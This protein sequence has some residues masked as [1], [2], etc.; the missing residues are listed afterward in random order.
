MLTFDNDD[1]DAGMSLDPSRKAPGRTPAATPSPFNRPVRP[2][3]VPSAPDT[4]AEK[5]EPRKSLPPKSPFGTP[6]KPAEKT[7][8]APL[9]KRLPTAPAKKEFLPAK[10]IQ[11]NF[12][13][14]E[15]DYEEPVVEADT[16]EANYLEDLLAKHTQP[17]PRQPEYSQQQTQA[18]QPAYTPAPSH[19]S[20]AV[21]TPY[22][23]PPVAL[24]SPE[25]EPVTRKGK[26]AKKSSKKEP[27][28]KKT[29][30][31]KPE[32]VWD[33]D[34][35][36]ILY[37]RLGV[38]LVAG[39]LLIAGMKSIVAPNNGPSPAQVKA[40]AQEAVNYTG[41]PTLSGEQFSID[42]ART[43]FNYDNN[44]DR[45][46]EAL[47]NFGSEELIKKV[48]IQPI[49]AGEYT[50]ANPSSSY[51]DYSVTQKVTYGPY[52]VST[53]NRDE[54]NAV[55]TVKV[56]LDSGAVLYMDVPVK[57][58]AKNYS[59]TLAGPPSFVKPIQN[60][61]STEETEYTVD[62]G[63]GDKDI[64]AD[65][66]PDLEAYLNAWA[67]SDSTIVNRYLLEGATDNA[68]KG[69]QKSVQFKSLDEFIVEPLDEARPNTAN[70][71]R[72]EI[73]VTWFDPATG[74]SYPQ[75]YRMLLGL[76]QENNWSVYDIENFAIL[77]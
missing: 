47:A 6:A 76:N 66:T 35:K 11:N 2:T 62:F 65:F 4:A 67:L 32:K 42:F 75:Q 49:S 48:D 41:F 19:Q 36:K 18:P 28:A 23:Q 1:N 9:P 13:N 27:K 21:S 3:S 10:P 7:P 52:V 15:P 14:S 43:Y 33:G 26:A 50:A 24:S 34:R 53:D 31:E 69:L 56:G 60:T 71:R 54:N 61:G 57:Y 73:T 22:T 25:E 77:N 5:S 38:G 39:V 29:A 16:E 45:R 44:D 58:N 20:A 8:Q 40:A 37:I 63:S 68:K 70:A 51:N 72:A 64:Q 30:K 46:S 59:L 74:L 55:F 12:Q 17:E